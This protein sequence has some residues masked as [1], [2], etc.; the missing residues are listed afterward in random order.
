MNRKG[1]NLGAI[2]RNYP[3]PAEIQERQANA[4]T[5]RHAMVLHECSAAALDR[6]LG[7]SVGATS[8]WINERGDVPQDKLEA[9]RQLIKEAQGE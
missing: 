5:V 9:C 2:R 1:G 6:K 4:R 7:A 3:T 8:R